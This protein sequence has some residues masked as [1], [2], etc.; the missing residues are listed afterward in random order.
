MVAQKVVSKVMDKKIGMMEKEKESTDKENQF[1][2]DRLKALEALV[3]NQQ[4]GTPLLVEALGPVC[5][6]RVMMEAAV[7]WHRVISPFWAP[8]L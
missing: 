8:L 3:I 1:L 7:P 2:M 4:N 5:L 6:V